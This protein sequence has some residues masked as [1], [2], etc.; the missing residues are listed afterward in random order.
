MDELS[1]G[2]TVELKSGGPKMTVKSVDG[3]NV[4]CLWFSSG[5]KLNEKPFPST[6]LSLVPDVSMLLDAV[7][8][9]KEI[10][11]AKSAEAMK[12]VRQ[13]MAADGEGK[14]ETL[15]DEQDKF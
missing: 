15:S 13:R 9:A 2:Q 14:G 4:V 1:E 10:Q 7:N 5:D 11:A 12:S 6:C 8:V 3:P